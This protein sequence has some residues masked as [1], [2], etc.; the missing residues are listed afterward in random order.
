MS[1]KSVKFTLFMTIFI[2]FSGYFSERAYWF[3]FCN[4]VIELSHLVPCYEPELP[5]QVEIPRHYNEGQS[6]MIAAGTTAIWE[7][8]TVYSYANSAG[9]SLYF[10]NNY[11]DGK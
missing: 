2:L 11:Y 3:G 5:K 10:N 9:A 4:S 7:G 6:I 8:T 1:I